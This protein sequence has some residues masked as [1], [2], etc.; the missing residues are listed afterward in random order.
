MQRASLALATLIVVSLAAPVFAQAARATGTVKDTSGKAMKGA[1]VKA[2]NKDA[3]PPEITSS[4][5][6]KGRWAMIGL[7]T[8]TWNFAVEAPG[9]SAQQAQWPVRVGGTQPMHFVL[10]RDLGPIPNALTRDIQ[11]QLTA[12]NA[13]RDKGQF[14]QALAAYEQIREQ[15]P[16]LTSMNLVV[17]GVYRQKAAQ[18]NDPT[19]RRA[20]FDRAIASYTA[21]LAS[22]A[23]NQRAKIELESTR[24]EAATTR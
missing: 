16:T 11:Q 6:D 7:R 21:M 20:L 2:T 15:N 13:L 18:E 19:A 3:Y 1:T 8:G 23:E 24:S 9:F 4:T 17:G 22:D 14:D 5:D 10:A 12:A